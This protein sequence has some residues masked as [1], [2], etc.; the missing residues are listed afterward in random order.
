[1]RK[2]IHTE[3]E[4]KFKI[5]NPGG[6]RKRVKTIGAEFISRDFEHDIYYNQPE[7]MAPVS[8]VR[9]RIVNK[10]EGLFTLKSA[11]SGNNSR[12]LKIRKEWETSIGNPDV[13]KAIL[14]E[15]GFCPYR[16]KE[17]IRE[18]YRLKK[19]LI[20][21]DRIP[22]IGWYAEIEG[23]EPQ[24]KRIAGQIGLNFKKSIPESYFELFNYYKAIKK[25]PDLKLLF[26]EKH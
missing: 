9:L 17:K 26:L 24:I 3:I 22:F 25:K 13:F 1:M 19:A 5:K 23:K 11:V 12:N 15:L 18:T 20:C 21:L 7:R 14:Q 4:T 2:E 16:E 10:A 8:T 6:F